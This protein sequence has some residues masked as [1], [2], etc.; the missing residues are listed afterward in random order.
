MKYTN[1]MDISL[2]EIQFFLAVAKN[3]S[4]TEAANV[5]YITQPLLS[6]KIA[7]LEQEIGEKLFYRGKQRI[8]LTPVGEQLYIEWGLLIEQIDKTLQNIKLAQKG[9]SNILNLCCDEM[10][11]PVEDYLFPAIEIFK[12]QHP[13]IAVELESFEFS[14]LRHRLLYGMTN[15]VI[16]G[17]SKLPTGDKDIIWE[18]LAILPNYVGFAKSHPL[19]RLSSVRW[20]DLRDEV[21]LV[22]GPTTSTDYYQYFMA[23]C[24]RNGFKPLIKTYQN[25]RSI[26]LNLELG[27]GIHM[28]SAY[29][30]GDD[31]KHIVTVRLEDSYTH[32]VIGRK[33]DCDYRTKMFMNSLVESVKGNIVLK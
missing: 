10:I 3:R 12:E 16:T 4:F 17:A 19:A 21:F 22:I 20:S 33:N 1:L 28:G 32:L 5:L 6:R 9:Y 15:V 23:E 31:N 25:K 13:N 11:Q 8:E 18:D 30:F 7:A 29:G 2:E 14:E 27:N 26:M 24:K